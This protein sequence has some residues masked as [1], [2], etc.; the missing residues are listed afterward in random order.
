MKK[1]KKV[2]DISQFHVSKK[3]NITAKGA[4]NFQYKMLFWWGS[5]RGSL[6]GNMKLYWT[7]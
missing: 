4:Y 2:R 1:G 6:K 7:Y 3:D 5:I